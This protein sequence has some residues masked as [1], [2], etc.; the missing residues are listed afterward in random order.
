MKT[1]G[2]D[3]K[4]TYVD[5]G[6]V[7]NPRAQAGAER[8]LAEARAGRQLVVMKFDQLARSI[9]GASDTAPETTARG[10]GLSLRG[11]VCDPTDP[12]SKLLFNMYTRV[13]EFE[14]DRIRMRTR[15]ATPVAKANGRP[16]GKKLKLS[17]AQEKHLVAL[18]KAGKDKT[19]ELAHEVEA[20]WSTIYGEVERADRI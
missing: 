17:L 16:R 3:E 4:H 11:R 10:A 1:R 15:E 20:T 18:S 13:A 14:A 8:A 5:F 12:L 6:F 9:R 7:G 19:A 2:V